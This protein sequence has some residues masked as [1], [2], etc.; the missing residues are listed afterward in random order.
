[1]IRKQCYECLEAYELT[2][3]GY[4]ERCYLYYDL[5]KLGLTGRKGVCGCLELLLR[6]MEEDEK[7]KQSNEH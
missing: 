4:D 3:V 5:R 1:M 6:K 2:K 7:D